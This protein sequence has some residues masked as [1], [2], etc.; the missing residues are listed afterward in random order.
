MT[1][2]TLIAEL[3][4]LMINP[5]HV[6]TPSLENPSSSSHWIPSINFEASTHEVFCLFI[7]RM[8]VRILHLQTEWAIKTLGIAWNCLA[9][10]KKDPTFQTPGQRL[11]CGRPVWS[12]YHAKQNRKINIL[13]SGHNPVDVAR[14]SA[15]GQFNWDATQ[16]I[17]SSIAKLFLCHVGIL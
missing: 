5:Q 12:G 13:H 1:E 7:R 8:C 16:G 4:V 11:N 17:V 2:E 15:D 3:Y 9:V 6:S 10:K 14:C